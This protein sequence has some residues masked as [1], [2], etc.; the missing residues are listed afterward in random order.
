MTCS[1]R[2]ITDEE[3]SI[4]KAEVVW[5]LTQRLFPLSI[6]HPSDYALAM[7]SVGKIR[8]LLQILEY[9]QSGR[10]Y[11]TGELSEF[12]GVSK[13]TIFRD[14][15]VLQDSGVQLLYD[16][17]EQGYWIPPSTF[18]PPTDLTVNETRSLLLLGEK[19]GGG[20]GIPLQTSARDGA[21]KL[22]ANLPP[23]LRSQ[24]SDLSDRVQIS[25][26]P[27]QPLADSQ[28]HYQRVLEAIEKRRKIRLSYDSLAEKQ[29]ISTLV[30]PYQMLFQNRSWYVIGRSSLH[31][32]VRTFHVGRIQSSIITNDSYEIPPRFTL[33]KYFGN[34][35]RM[36]REE[37][38]VEVIV[39]FKPLVAKNVS[40][41][42]WHSTQRLVWNPDGSL[43]FHA[44]VAG[45][46]EISWWILGY[47]DQAEVLA[48][49][50]LRELIFSHI[51][52]MASA[53]PAT[54]ESGEDRSKAKK[55][56]KPNS[57]T[58]PSKSSS[59]REAKKSTTP[60][61]ASKT[62]QP[63][64]SSKPIKSTKPKRPTKRVRGHQ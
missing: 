45:I 15:K 62:T 57:T 23:Q 2:C 12:V 29:Q 47:G 46:R 4:P 60:S 11:H 26:K 16:D 58:K 39:R 24:L 5:F 36:I 27:M 50:S 10:K 32:E 61:Q 20:S 14:L 52:K 13:R 17:A 28:E 38:E 64:K 37:P 53:Y 33:K 8:R 51:Q 34:A 3:F 31:K 63:T 54:V 21:L 44:Q 25:L 41:V 59:T 19:L 40:E 9:L 56:T 49:R 18:L 6:R 30:S 1:G 22:L 42:Q 43:N 35:W 7:S 48:P 55:A